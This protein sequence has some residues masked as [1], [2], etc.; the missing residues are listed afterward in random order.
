MTQKNRMDSSTYTMIMYQQYQY[1]HVMILGITE[2]YPVVMNDHKQLFRI[3]TS[4]IDVH[5]RYIL[6]IND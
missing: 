6:A 1:H 2:Q 3:L 5:H 4:L